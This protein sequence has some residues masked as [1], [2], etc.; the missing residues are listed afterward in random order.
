MMIFWKKYKV[1]ELD[2]ILKHYKNKKRKKKI[3]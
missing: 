3:K 1:L 2:V